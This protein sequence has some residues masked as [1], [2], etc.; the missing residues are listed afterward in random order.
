MALDYLQ[1]PFRYDELVKLLKIGY[2][3][4][5]FRNLLRLQRLGLAVLKVALSGWTGK[6]SANRA[7]N[8]NAPKT[9]AKIRVIRG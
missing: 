5:P 4:A 2:G 7:N 8:A 9:F 1:I 6:R 3:G